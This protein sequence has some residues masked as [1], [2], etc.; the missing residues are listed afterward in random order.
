VGFLR[1]LVGRSGDPGVTGMTMNVS[2]F[3]RVRDDAT[4]HV[5]GEAYRQEN[6]ALA[7]PPGPDDLPPG[8]PPPPSG[9]FKAML[10]G[11]PTNPYDRNAI[12]VA[13]WSGGSWSLVG[14]LAKEDAASYQPVLRHL[15]ASS[16]SDSPPAIACDAALRAERGGT[17][18]VLNLGTP[19]ECITERVIEDRSPLQHGWAGKAIA[20][21]GQGVS[22]IHGIPLDRPAQI[23]LARWAGCDVL[24]RLTKKT[25]ALVAAAPEDS[26]GNLVRAREYGVAVIEER[27]FLVAIGVPAEVIGR[28]Q[29]WANG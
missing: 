15:G 22:T 1:R 11:Q 16:G 10:F 18:V 8:M 21:T 24:P 26:T 19:A 12:A 5:V 13:L 6:V 20:F 17:G 14:Y 2:Y 23:M 27:D 4:L 28:A 29:R 9:Y 25:A 7:R 3:T